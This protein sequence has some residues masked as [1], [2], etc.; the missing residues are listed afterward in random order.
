MPELRTRAVFEHLNHEGEKVFAQVNV[1][2][3]NLK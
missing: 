3:H 2:V 1:I